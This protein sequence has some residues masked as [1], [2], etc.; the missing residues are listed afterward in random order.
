MKPGIVF[1]AIL[2]FLVVTVPYA[3]PRIK[4]F[5]YKI[6]RCECGENDWQTVPPEQVP[7]ENILPEPPQVTMIPVYRWCRGC[8]NI[9]SF[10]QNC[11]WETRNT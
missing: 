6:G 1:L 2:L 8:G 3:W 4:E 10:Y 9:R 11:D 7:K 5:F